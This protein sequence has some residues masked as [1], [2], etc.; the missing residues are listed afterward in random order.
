MS[1]SSNVEGKVIKYLQIRLLFWTLC[2]LTGTY[3]HTYMCWLFS[4]LWIF[5]TIQKTNYC[6]AKNFQNRR[7]AEDILISRLH[8]YK[9]LNF[10]GNI[11]WWCADGV[12]SMIGKYCGDVPMVYS[13]WL[14]NIVVMCRWCNL[15]DWK[16]LWW[17]ANGV[18]SMIGKHCGDVLMVYRLWW[19]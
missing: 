9:D 1:L 13:L 7:E 19:N 8:I 17:C 3:I 4:I 16:T 10:H 18:T 12:P 14:E 6:V 11:L 15:Y 5:M 2:P